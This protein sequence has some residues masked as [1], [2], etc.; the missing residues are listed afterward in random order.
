MQNLIVVNN[1]KDWPTEIEGSDVVGARAY[2]TDP[3]CSSL[4]NTR[5]FNLCKSYRYQSAGYYVSLLAAARGHKPMP[6]ISTILDFKNQSLVR[7]VSDDLDDL[8]QSSLKQLVS[9]DFVLSI[10]FGK[11]TAK[12]YDRLS[13]RLFKMFPAPFLRAHF[14]Y[15]HKWQMTSISA[16]S[17]GEIPPDHFDFAMYMTK[18]YF[19]GKRIS[20]PKKVSVRYD[21]AILYDPLEI[22]SPSD[23]KAVQKFLKAAESIGLGT[24]VISK[25]DYGRIAQFDALFIRETTSVN[26]HTF[27]FSRRAA[28]EGLVVI[29]DPESILKC[30][31]KVYLAELMQRHSLPVPT[32]MVVHQKNRKTVAELLGLPCILK[33]PDSSF[34][35]GVMKVE[36]DQELQAALDVMLDKSDLVIAQVFMPTPYDWRIGI[37]DR[38]PLFSC[39]YH[40]AKNHWQ[41][42]KPSTKGYPDF[43][44]VET[45]AIDDAPKYIVQTALKSANLIGDGLYGVDV[46]EVG[47][48][49]FVMEVNENPNIEAG[50]EDTVLKDALYEAVMKVFMA[51]I[52]QRKEKQEQKQ[53]H[54]QSQDQKPDQ[55]QEQERKQ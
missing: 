13:M 19:A 18:E 28:A 32:T 20:L 7:F 5:V 52:E 46:K 12:R 25:D 51:R 49:C 53:N 50:Y 44:K 34:S 45:F 16:L 55:K 10:Y 2:L 1:A 23:D 3:K 6:S 38:K 9:D 15:H 14:H 17:A 47:K 26:H 36:T 33:Q 42:L 8:I 40:M 29:D 48:K 21:L 11:N 4:R 37:L 41:I 24:E 30:T 43:G 31:N 35:A 54:N 27:R 39:K 22:T